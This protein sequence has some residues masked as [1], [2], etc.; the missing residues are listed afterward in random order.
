MYYIYW[1]YYQGRSQKEGTDEDLK[2]A[3]MLPASMIV[4]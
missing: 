3:P 1:I 2:N 4:A